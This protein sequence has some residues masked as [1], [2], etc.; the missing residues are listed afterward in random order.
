L[1]QYPFY[2]GTGAPHE[3]GEGAGKGCTVNLALPAESG[4]ATYADA[5]RRVIL[6]ALARFEAD[7]VLVSA[8][9]DAHA[10]DPLA[11]MRLDEAAYHAMATALVD[12]VEARG[13]G[14]LACVLE[15]G[16]DLQALEG[17]VAAVVRAMRGE[18]LA[19]P[20]DAAPPA[21][22]AAV[23]ATLRALGWTT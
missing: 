1:H 20:E 5:F 9:F 13:H 8:G 4:P 6:P 14:R 16:Y 12:H 18:G 3:I 17:S 15:G 19:L 10:R 23:D 21:G 11:H 2:P 7:L 22:R